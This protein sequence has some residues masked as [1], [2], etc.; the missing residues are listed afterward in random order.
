MAEPSVSILN[1]TYDALDRL[2]KITYPDSTTQTYT[3]DNDGNVLKLVDSSSTLY[4]TLQ[5]TRLGRD[6]AENIPSQR[7]S[8][9]ETKP[10]FAYHEPVGADGST[11]GGKGNQYPSVGYH[12]FAVGDWETRV[13]P[14]VPNGKV[15]II[16]L[17][18]WN[19]YGR[20]TS[21]RCRSSCST[22][23]DIGSREVSS[24]TWTAYATC[25][26]KKIHRVVVRRRTS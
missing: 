1:Y 17:V 7:T 4:Y 5:R 3:Y 25:A 13:K 21:C 2:T 15:V 23:E 26:R 19:H 9:T 14:G 6:K 11:P 12:E 20:G 16:S 8:S 24:E 10:W 22:V 18:G